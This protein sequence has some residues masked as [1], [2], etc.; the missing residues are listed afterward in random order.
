MKKVLVL[1]L[2]LFT[3]ILTAC[4]NNK[5][6]DD[7]TFMYWS[8]RELVNRVDYIRSNTDWKI[9]AID[10]PDVMYMPRL[11]IMFAAAD[12]PDIFLLPEDPFYDMAKNGMLHKLDEENLTYVDLEL[13]TYEGEVYGVK[14]DRFIFVVSS[15]VED[16][17]L[18][19][20]FLE[21]FLGINNKKVF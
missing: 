18:A 4:G 15:F 13:M 6:E 9:E 14:E 2:I 21:E 12:Y 20:D 5:T 10:I 11:L 3:L 7:L 17:D 16:Y 8:D 19:I 1:V